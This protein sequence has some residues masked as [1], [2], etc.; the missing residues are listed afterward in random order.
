M[1]DRLRAAVD[2][3]NEGD[4]QPFAS[5]FADDA[6]W[7]GVSRGF[8]WWKDA[9]SWRGPD[10]AREVLQH[11]MERLGRQ[12]FEMRPKFVEVTKDRIIGSATWLAAD[13][14]RDDRY[15]VLTIRD[16]KIADMQECGSLR[17]AKRFAR[18]TRGW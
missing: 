16:G 17:Q 10:E 9:P 5:L 7:R 13:G 3:L 4:P 15:H 2:A 12:G 18:R 1:V 11:H 8:L 6:E 14:G